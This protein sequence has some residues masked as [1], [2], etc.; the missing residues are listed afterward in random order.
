MAREPE[1]KRAMVFIDGQNLFHAAKKRFGSR[2]PD[3]DVI[4]LS[5]Y[6]CDLHRWTLVRTHFY[7]GVPSEDRDP[8]WY[9]FWQRKLLGMGRRGVVVFTRPLRYHRNTVR[10]DDG[11]TYTFSTAEEKGIDVRIALDV[12]RL[13]RKRAY[14]VAVIFS[15]DQDLSEVAVEIRTIA[16]DQDRWIKVASAYPFDRNVPS[17]RGIDRTDW[18]RIPREVYEACRDPRD[19][20]PLLEDTP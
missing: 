14:D 18:I 15:Q 2:W 12:I 10:L 11:S 13:A 19:Y 3:Y 5:R 1:I 8:Y 7:T 16:R 6:V 9:G 20:R 17:G 4:K